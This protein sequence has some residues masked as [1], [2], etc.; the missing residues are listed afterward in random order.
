[1]FRLTLLILIGVSLALKLKGFE[2]S[3]KEIGVMFC[4][5]CSLS[6]YFCIF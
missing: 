6:V 2:L 5:F 3:V 4:V 1:M